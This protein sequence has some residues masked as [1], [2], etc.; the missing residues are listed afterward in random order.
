MVK[1]HYYHQRRAMEESIGLKGGA[2]TFPFLD[3]G[4]APRNLL[5]IGDGDLIRNMR[6]I[7]GRAIANAIRG[8]EGIEF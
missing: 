3:L 8:G 7:L 5:S 4:E 6:G 1:L 2:E